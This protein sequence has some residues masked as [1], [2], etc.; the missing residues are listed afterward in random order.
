MNFLKNVGESVAAALS[1]LGK[2]LLVC[3][4]LPA[5]PLVIWCAGGCLWLPLGYHGGM[6]APWPETGKD[7]LP[8]VSLCQM[9]YHRPL[10]CSSMNQPLVGMIPVGRGDQAQLQ[11]WPVSFCLLVLRA[12]QPLFSPDVNLGVSSRTWVSS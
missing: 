10:E 4:L 9:L 5:E 11:S 1:P 2:W 3:P 8:Q 6:V 12:K 7:G